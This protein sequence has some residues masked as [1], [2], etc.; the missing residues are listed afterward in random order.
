MTIS[1][2][3]S[4]IV[5]SH[6][7]ALPSLSNISHVMYM[8]KISKSIDKLR[9]FAKS[10]DVVGFST[11]ITALLQQDFT[12]W[13]LLLKKQKLITLFR[14]PSQI[15]ELKTLLSSEALTNVA[16]PDFEKLTHHL[17][18]CEFM[19]HVF[20]KI[21]AEALV[22]PCRTAAPENFVR[23]VLRMIEIANYGFQRNAE[24][25]QVSTP[26]R[27][28][29]L[30]LAHLERRLRDILDTGNVILNSPVATTGTDKTCEI[31]DD[32][33]NELIRLAFL[34]DEMR[35]TFDL[36]TYQD[37]EVRI[38]RRSLVLKI[39]QSESNLAAAVG[40]ERT[41]DHDQVRTTVLG[42]L[43]LETRN[44]CRSVSAS[45]FDSFFRFLQ[46]LEGT[47]AAA[48]AR[49]FGLAFVND[50][51]FEISSFFEVGTS[52]VTR[53]GTFTIDNLI[54]AWAFFVTIAMLG[55]EWNGK[56]ADVDRSPKKQRGDG[57]RGYL[58]RNVSVPE[59][60]RHW[61]VRMLSRETCVTREQARQLVNQFT[62]QPA[63]G[64]I[65]LFYK[66]LVLLSGNNIA[67]PTP[68]LRGSR[69]ERNV[70][71][72]IATETDLDQKK[73]G[74]IPVLELERRFKDAGFWALSNFSVQ[75]NHRE[76][77]DIDLVAFKD[78]Y[79]FL[80]Q[81]KIVI[82]PDSLYDAWKAENKLEFA[83]TQLDACIAHLNEVRSELFNRLGLKYTKETFVRPFILTNTRQFTERRFRGHPVVDVAYV[84]FLLGG[85]RA[86]IIGTSRG[87]IG[88]GSG[89]SYIE[90]EH[91]TGEELS[92]LFRETI[93]KVQKR[94]I[95]YRHVLRK[96]GDRK[97]HIPLLRMRTA[98]DSHFLVTGD[99]IFDRDPPLQPWL[100]T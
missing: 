11:H 71:V 63:A 19:Q 75:I 1:F 99:E 56:R 27:I 35:Q 49:N 58:V 59:L 84:R 16:G 96:I 14:D 95:S 72:L 85:A 70:F 66:P 7:K 21:D 20:A 54:R 83:A 86:S 51:K 22:V 93:H 88:F 4:A 40:A 38:R 69:F 62:S 5:D 90:G 77:T 55:Q 3:K 92:R 100:K 45:P 80:G 61:L 76:I 81:C 12:G 6:E 30:E 94:D 29:L 9:Q 50:L 53:A 44:A 37:A 33:L 36:Y 18:V 79:L 47:D 57:P 60:N 28:T 2:N 23:S 46:C 15:S 97:V 24:R 17:D 32:D 68:Y 31:A 8:E 10:K 89:R 52:V 43:E 64:R 25:R 39:T 91:P 42:K 65:D 26:E 87:E 98:G 41:S 67:L 48:Y 13:L 82:E 73:K 74:Y 34:Y 78:G